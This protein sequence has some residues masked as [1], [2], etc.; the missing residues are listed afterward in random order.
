MSDCRPWRQFPTDMRCILDGGSGVVTHCL[1]EDSAAHIIRCVN[2]HDDLLEACKALVRYDDTWA[3]G[4]PGDDGHD[5]Y[6]DALNCI[7]AA[8]ARAT[9]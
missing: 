7:R 4:D 5:S 3:F 9:A 8:I 6:N 1:R 2:A